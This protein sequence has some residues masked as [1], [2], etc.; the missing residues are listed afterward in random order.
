MKITATFNS[1]DLKDKLFLLARGARVSQADVMKEEARIIVE[2]VMRL[3]PPST[4]A[5]GRKA[6]ARDLGK[7]YSSVG[8]VLKKSQNMA[9]QGKEQWRA[10]LTRASK[11]NDEEAMRELLTRPISGVETVTVRPYTRNG[12][13]VAGYQSQRPFS[14][15]SL[16]NI[17]GSTQIGG[18]LDRN[19]HKARRDRRGHVRRGVLSQ[20]VTKNTE[21][22]NYR[23]EIQER[24]S[25]HMAGWVP[26]TRLV[27][28][29][30]KNWVKNSRLAAK[31]GSARANFSSRGK[32]F[33]LGTNFDVKIPNYQRVIDAVMSARIRVAVTKINRLNRGLATNLGFTRIAAK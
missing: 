13:A 30:V 22:N 5:Q 23:K 8:A 2:N 20:V 9:F 32:V 28:A 24:V 12:V 15:P 7:I 33:A 26:F 6:V 18:S 29:N 21:L 27:G 19:L 4:Y 31:S 14:S 1:R 10:A 11:A 16:P 25:W 3:T 17:G